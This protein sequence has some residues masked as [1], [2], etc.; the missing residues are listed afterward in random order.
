[1][2]VLFLTNYP[3]PYRIDFF[4]E[5]GKMCEL[6]VLFEQ[7]PDEVADREQMGIT[8]DFQRFE[9]E[10]FHGP[11]IKLGCYYLNFDALSWVIKANKYDVVVFG[12]YSSPTQAMMITL[13]KLLRR[14]YVL[15]SD[16]GFIK[17]D[18]FGVKQ[19]KS[20]LIRNATMYLASGE[21]TKRYLDHYGA[22]L[23]RVRV[24][25]FT[26]LKENDVT[27]E[28]ANKERIAM[29]RKQYGI[30]EKQVIL[31][32]GQFIKRKGWDVLLKAAQTLHPCVGIYIIGGNE[33]EE[34]R[35]LVRQY[36]LQTVHFLPFME[37]EE[38][39]DYYALSDLFVL[40]TREDIWGLVINEAM[41]HGLP[42]ITTKKCLA[43][44]ELV[45]DGINGFLIENED[46]ELLS[47]R[48][49]QILENDVLREQMK[50]NNQVKIQSYTIENMAK[51]TAD[52]LNGII[53]N[54]EKPHLLE[55]DK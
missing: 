18:R 21:S 26:S 34:Y 31:G 51:V 50:R 47:D 48:I 9:G 4:N 1:M 30:P 27:K 41:A 49:N 53:C 6:T 15:S 12:I 10:F 11:R 8:E 17:N 16:G 3:V 46:A 22:D 14:A 5:L 40:P 43:G 13:M 39:S 42:V 23:E 55:R 52:I 54:K 24:Y 37:K 36:G 44:L 32:V 28:P 19:I 7:G 35:K 45:E 33:T 2:K 29:L 25:P 20:F 38:L